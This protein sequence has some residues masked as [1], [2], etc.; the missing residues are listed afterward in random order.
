MKR[1]NLIL[2]TTLSLCR[3]ASA[4]TAWVAPESMKIR[5]GDQP[6]VTHAASLESARN[7]FEAFHVVL[8]GGAKGLK[9]ASV[10]ATPLSGPGGASIGGVHLYR[11]A[12]YNV[13]TPS[14]VDGATGPWPDALIPAVDE[15]V[16]ET[17]NAFPI[18]VPAHQQ[19]PVYVEYFV[20]ADATPGMYTGSVH[21][22]SADG[23]AADVP[24]TLAV[25]GF[26]LPSTSSLR[27]AFGMGWA[28]ACT[29]HFGGYQA[30]G[31]DDGIAK[32]MLM[33]A[34]FA[35][36]HRISIDSSIYTGPKAAPAGGFDW[37]TWDQM[38]GPLIDGTAPTR[39]KGAKLTSVRFSWTKDPASYA[40][41]AKHFK[42]KGWFDRTFDYTCDEPPAECNWNELAQRAAVVRA[43]DPTF[44]TLTTT[45]L[46]Q[47]TANGVA[48]A[49]DML[50]P[51]INELSP[52]GASSLRTSYD[53]WLG[54]SQQRMIWSYQSCMSDGCNIVG[55]ESGWP[56]YMID[57]SAL[58]NRAMEWNSWRNRISG[59]LYYEMTYALPRGDAWTNQFYFG[60]NGD[61]TL[62]YPGTP[63]RI[64]GK[65]D[66]PVASLRLKMIRAGM[67]DYE[68]LKAVSDA[69]DPILADAEAARL[70]PSSTSFTK[71]P[72]ALDSA[73]HRIAARADELLG[74]H[75][76]NMPTPPASD[77][78]GPTAPSD[79]SSPTDPPAQ[80]K[81][82]GCSVQGHSPGA[83]ALSV[84]LSF[85]LALALCLRRVRR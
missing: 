81:A 35:L 37:A 72:A 58:A 77:G 54:A 29:A 38:Y 9:G 28:D 14:S 61:G 68:Y 49:I 85:G 22:A 16:G 64:G 4:Q 27:T 43:G 78:S 50:V 74:Y 83:G 24:V 33:Y 39:L 2:A 73:R 65:T 31:G 51:V 53:A 20:P 26:V 70:A 57:R 11:E 13:T 79:S 12:F 30:C 52:M 10:T 80:A 3:L 21:V 76:D 15:V 75:L 1:H 40:E 46:A 45:T 32:M 63:A 62:F 25:H 71:D 23:F 55:Q 56:S 5:P 18:D 7:E 60:N 17:R 36:D 42:Q 84:L 44:R 19:Q 47:A 48:S 41:W 66:I 59:E 69:G 6:G 67:E 34:R 82:G 8:D